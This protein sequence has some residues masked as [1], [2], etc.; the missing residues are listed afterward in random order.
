MIAGSGKIIWILVADWSSVK[1]S[2]PNACDVTHKIRPLYFILDNCACPRIEVY[3]QSGKKHGHPRLYGTYSRRAEKVNGW[4][5]YTSDAYGGRY[6]IWW[7]QEDTYPVYQWQIGYSSNKGRNYPLAL[8]IQDVECPQSLKLF[9]WWMN[10]GGW[11]TFGYDL[12]SR[13][14]PND[15]LDDIKLDIYEPTSY[16]P[17]HAKTEIPKIVNILTS[18]PWWFKPQA[19]GFVNFSPRLK[20]F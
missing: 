19:L 5:F 12:G 8:N 15:D 14:L 13:C 7:Y 1:S 6:G 10:T 20:L 17:S 4:P 9:S 2:E 16:T 3:S 18:N 11:Y